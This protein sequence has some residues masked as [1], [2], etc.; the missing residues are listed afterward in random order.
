MAGI[1]IH[2]PFCV[3]KCHYCNFFSQPAL[4]LIP[5]YVNALC[6]ELVLR[7]AYLNE[8]VETIYF[9]GGTPSLL[10]P[11]QVDAILNTIYKHFSLKLHEA[12]FE[13]NPDELS[14]S[15]LHNI[16]CSGIN[17]LSIGIQSFNDRD[18]T[19][20][21]RRHSGDQAQMAVCNARKTGF[22]NISIDLIYGIPIQ[23]LGQWEEQINIA[24]GLTPEH[25]SAY[26]LTVEPGTALHHF[27]NTKK[28]Q[29]VSDEHSRACFEILVQKLKTA[30]Y[31]HY[32]V[33]NFS[34]PGRESMHNSAYWN[35]S[36][37]LGVG[38]SAHSYNGTSR[39]WNIAA[40]N[41]YINALQQKAIPAEK[42]ILSEKDKINEYIMTHLRTADGI[43]NE[44]IRENFGE[45]TF[46]SVRSK[47]TLYIN[48]GL[49]FETNNHICTTEEGWFHLDGIASTLFE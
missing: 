15:Y 5:A 41:R 18:L 24:T 19:W 27:I 43:H 44:Y 2:I 48:N 42:E 28:Y 26:A 20:L 30:G 37:Y 7:K 11:S 3:K 22:D 36:T 33:S 1:Y 10:Q 29:P 34:L 21:N 45:D 39:Q 35:Q 6:D 16:R 31:Y 25:I 32:E 12:T 9:G 47:A 13:V 8:P 17:R 40:I 4:D 49:L 23:S 38:A 14:E 46:N